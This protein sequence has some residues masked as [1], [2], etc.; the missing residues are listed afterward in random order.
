MSMSRKDFIALADSLR[1]ALNIEHVDA[2]GIKTYGP[3]RVIEAVADFC[4][5]QNSRF[6]R[7]RWLG[8]LAGTNGPRGKA[9]KTKGDY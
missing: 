3:A 7:G 6:N 4:Q 9:T 5:N 1:P 2:N 8:Y